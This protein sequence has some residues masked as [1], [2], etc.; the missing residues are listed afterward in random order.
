MDT[1]QK[2]NSLRHDIEVIFGRQLALQAVLSEFLSMP[3]EQS[4][5]LFRRVRALQKRL[6]A[7]GIASPLLTETSLDEFRATLLNLCLSTALPIE[8]KP[9]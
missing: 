6:E 8:K 2:L 1:E 3:T 9:D 5:E 7:D 4:T